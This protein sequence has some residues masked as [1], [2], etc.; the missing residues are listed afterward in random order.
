MPP[1]SRTVCF[2]KFRGSDASWTRAPI[3]G[4]SVAREGGRVKAGAQDSSESNNSRRGGVRRRAT[5]RWQ[6]HEGYWDR[7]AARFRFWALLVSNKPGSARLVSLKI[8]LWT[9]Y[10]G[11]LDDERQGTAAESG[12]PT[13]QQATAHAA[14][15]YPDGGDRARHEQRQTFRRR[16]QDNHGERQWL[17]GFAGVSR[18][19]AGNRFRLSIPRRWKS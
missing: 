14:R 15:A 2:I 13:L 9:R 18:W 3:A 12:G 16:D 4:I 19:R 8:A 5:V 7:R 1:A 17:P 10:R 6:A 11:E